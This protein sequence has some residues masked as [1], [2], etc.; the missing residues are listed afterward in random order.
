VG[1]AIF[2]AGEF[3]PP[4]TVFWFYFFSAVRKMAENPVGFLPHPSVGQM[5][6]KIGWMAW[7]NQSDSKNQ[8]D[9][10]CLV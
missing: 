3:F 2:S 8:T 1:G 7:Q 10:G 5:L 4:T 6:T 9:F